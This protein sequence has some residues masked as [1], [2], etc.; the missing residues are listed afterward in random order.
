MCLSDGASVCQRKAPIQVLQAMLPTRHGRQAARAIATVVQTDAR[1]RRRQAR[2]RRSGG[3]LRKL[4]RR[5]ST[6]AFL[7]TLPL[8]TLMIGLVA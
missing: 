2:G 5:R 1:A 3:G 8:L 6:I 7:M 4:M